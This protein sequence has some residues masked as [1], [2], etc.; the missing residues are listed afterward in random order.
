MIRRAV[1]ISYC[2]SK[3]PHKDVTVSDSVAIT[4]I[5]AMSAENAK[6]HLGSDVFSDTVKNEN[7]VV[8]LYWYESP[9]S[10]VCDDFDVS[11]KHFVYFRISSVNP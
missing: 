9:F 7:G 1:S 2:E 4:L 11:F 3:P 8:S 6:K 5:I 10:I